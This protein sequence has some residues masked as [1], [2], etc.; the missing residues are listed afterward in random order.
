[1]TEEGSPPCSP[2]IPTFRSGLVFLPALRSH[3]HQLADAF[4]IQNL[5]RIVLENS[6]LNIEGKEL[7]GVIPRNADRWSE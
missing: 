5:E 1:M 4:L 3:L 7:A 2:Q 6:V